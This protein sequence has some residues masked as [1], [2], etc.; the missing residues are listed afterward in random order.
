[1]HYFMQNNFTE[2]PELI[3]TDADAYIENSPPYGPN[4][5]EV[6]RQSGTS[7]DPYGNAYSA[8]SNDSTWIERSEEYNNDDGGKF[9][10][11]QDLPNGTGTGFIPWQPLGTT[12]TA[13]EATMEYPYANFSTSDFAGWDG[14]TTDWSFDDQWFSTDGSA[15]SPSFVFQDSTGLNNQLPY[16]GAAMDWK[17]YLGPFKVLGGPG[18]ET[19]NNSLAG[20]LHDYWIDHALEGMSYPSTRLDPTGD[21]LDIITKVTI[22]PPS[23][24][25]LPVGIVDYYTGLDTVPVVATINSANSVG[26]PAG[27]T[28]GWDGCGMNVRDEFPGWTDA[29]DYYDSLSST[30][31]A[32]ETYCWP[33][34]VYTY[35]QVCYRYQMPT[36]IDGQATDHYG[37]NDQHH[38]MFWNGQN[39][40]EEQAK[41]YRIPAHIRPVGDDAE[42]TTETRFRF[43]NSYAPLSNSQPELVYNMGGWYTVSYL[44]N[45]YYTSEGAPAETY[46]DTDQ[47][48]WTDADVEFYSG[49]IYELPHYR[50]EVSNG[51]ADA[52][53]SLS[54]V[55]AGMTKGP[56]YTCVGRPLTPATG[57][58]ALSAY[59]ACNAALNSDGTRRRFYTFSGA[60]DTQTN[61]Q[62]GVFDNP[63]GYQQG[64]GFIVAVRDRNPAFFFA[65]VNQGYAYE[66]NT[67]ISKLPAD[68]KKQ[69]DDKFISQHVAGTRQWFPE[70]VSCSWDVVK[71]IAP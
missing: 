26:M 46:W 8:L 17:R 5:H 4:S 18:D 53:P 50:I 48:H 28:T 65:G 36:S 12:L 29:W 58:G 52:D 25:P 30:Y 68:Y 33:W 47:S 71:T 64:H 38:W 13:Y 62:R 34:G 19:G 55:W 32:S 24:D 54:S 3:F 40:T 1:M 44:S 49:I 2:Y 51:F 7:F 41:P 60:E 11:S 69:I 42:Y 23:G 16:P 67:F 9:T 21:H 63:F 6:N 43:Q 14:G 70:I 10:L 31:I 22:R 37:Y 35:P 66:Y 61:F 45:S 27:T 15:G 59:S 20:G 56:G 57:A 39:A